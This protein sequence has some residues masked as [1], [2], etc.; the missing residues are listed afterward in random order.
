MLP[1]SDDPRWIKIL[2]GETH[3]TF[4]AVAAGLMMSRLSRAVQHDSSPEAL[5][6][7]A[8]EMREFFVKYENVFKEDIRSIFG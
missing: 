5:K 6:K 2:K 1:K 4:K 8:E 3:Y 7:Y